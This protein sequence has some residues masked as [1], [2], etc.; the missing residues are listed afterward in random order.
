MARFRVV[1]SEM[2]VGS[3]CPSNCIFLLGLGIVML[4]ILESDDVLLNIT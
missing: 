2:P 3:A 1:G 4:E